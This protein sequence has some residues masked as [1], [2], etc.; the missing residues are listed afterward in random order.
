MLRT[1]VVVVQP[2]RLVDGQLDHLL[3][4][5]GQADIPG[6]RAV[7]PPD[8]ELDGRAHLV[9]FDT[10]IGEDLGRDAF[11]LADQAQKEVLS[12][13]VVVVEPLSLLL[14]KLQDLARPLGEFVKT[15]S[16][17]VSPSLGRSSGFL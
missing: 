15:V 11:A 17:Q 1:D 5:R 3:G 9:Q 14:R 6:H 16:H 13:D 2:P 7:A 12:A 8:D 4:A 10:E